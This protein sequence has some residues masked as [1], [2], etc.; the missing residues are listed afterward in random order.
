MLTAG[1]TARQNTLYRS[2]ASLLFPST[3]AG[4]RAALCISPTDCIAILLLLH[5]HTCRSSSVPVNTIPLVPS[6]P[7]SF[8]SSL[9]TGSAI[10][11]NV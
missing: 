6:P 7:Q 4:R 2:S 3:K 9:N 5:L 8:P 1:A 10:F 11:A